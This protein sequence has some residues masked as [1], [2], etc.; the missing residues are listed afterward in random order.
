M[1]YFHNDYLLAGEKIEVTEKLLSDYQLQII[2]DNNVCLGKNKKLIPNVGN[3]R[4]Y[5][6]HYQ[7]LNLYFNLGLQFKKMIDW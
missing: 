6:L 2:G 1:L 7:K 4:K 3:K 5:K